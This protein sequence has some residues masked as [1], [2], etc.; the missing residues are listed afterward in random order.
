MVVTGDSTVISGVG[1]RGPDLRESL[2]V[3]L[4]KG[5]IGWSPGG[6]DNPKPY[7]GNCTGGTGRR[8]FDG[9]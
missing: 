4:G 7:F 5:R 6:N 8:V 1:S 2:N 9:T 3:T